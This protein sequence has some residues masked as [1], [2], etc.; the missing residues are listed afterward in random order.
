M[1]KFIQVLCILTLFTITHQVSALNFLQALELAEQSDPEILAA[2]FD[3]RAVI[4]TRAQSKSAL[5]PTIQLSVFT[6]HTKQDTRNSS[7]PAVIQNGSISFDTNGYSLSLSQS[8]YSQGFQF[9][10]RSLHNAVQN[11]GSA[12]RLL[13]G[14]LPQ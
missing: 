14:N 6:S 11:R 3:H 7:Q 4:E 12:S 10:L 13:P 8:I 2:E 1:I 5:L 9:Q